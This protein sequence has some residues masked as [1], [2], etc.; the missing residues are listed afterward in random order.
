MT[1]SELRRLHERAIESATLLTLACEGIERAVD[2]HAARGGH[3]A[4]LDLKTESPDPGSPEEALNEE[5]D[6]ILADLT[7]LAGVATVVTTDLFVG[8]NK[9]AMMN[10]RNDI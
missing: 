4:A 6:A 2:V 7:L 1:V 9:N 10:L 3:A 5:V 8:S